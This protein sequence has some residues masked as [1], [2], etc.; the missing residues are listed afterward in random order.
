M[1]RKLQRVYFKT[2]R[3]L[4]NEPKLFVGDVTAKKTDPKYTELNR[5]D[6]PKYKFIKDS[7][8]DFFL[9]YPR[10]EKVS[11][12][13]EIINNFDDYIYELTLHEIFF[14]LNFCVGIHKGDFKGN[15][16]PDFRLSKL[17]VRI[18]AE[19][20]NVYDIKPEEKAKLKIEETIYNKINGYKSNYFYLKLNTL[21]LKKKVQ[22]SAKPILSE[23]HKAISKWP[24]SR[25]NTFVPHELKYED[26]NIV[27]RGILELRDPSRWNSPQTSFVGTRSY[28]AIYGNTTDSIRSAV[29]LKASK[30]G[31]M[32]GPFVI[33]INIL[34]ERGFF[35]SDI[36]DA[37]YGRGITHLGF[38]NQ[39]N[40]NTR[41]QDG[42]FTDPVKS[43][44]RVSG[45]LVTSI[46]SLFLTDSEYCYFVNPNA[47]YK[48]Y[49]N[50]LKTAKLD[51]DGFQI[52]YTEGK[53]F[54]DLI[55]K[56]YTSNIE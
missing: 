42:I 19:A 35:L 52:N 31:E 8:E 46:K 54:N 17:S 2:K 48:Q 44:S 12:K 32:N 24:K 22:P 39:E 38:G 25:L 14:N 41:D 26:A 6:F 30:Y 21:S 5:S 29:K 34:S 27:F 55:N 9:K 10:K 43:Y 50:K 4:F 33:C 18:Y 16:K 3:R 13:H 47:T 53:E 45:V 51:E 56:K 40:R 15:T 11:F 20:K 1:I 36:E 23:I 28:N 7:Y 49:F 37:L